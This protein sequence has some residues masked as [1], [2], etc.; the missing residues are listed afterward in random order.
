MVSVS[1]SRTR[2]VSALWLALEVSTFVAYMCSATKVVVSQIGLASRS[3][4]VAR[5]SMW[6][7]LLWRVCLFSM[8]PTALLRLCCHFFN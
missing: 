1:L 2:R 4:G 6:C 8:F 5:I 3:E 7:S